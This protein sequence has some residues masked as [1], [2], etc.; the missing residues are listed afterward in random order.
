MTPVNAAGAPVSGLFVGELPRALL[1]QLQ[2]LRVIMEQELEAIDSLLRRNDFNLQLMATV[3]ALMLGF[4]L[5]F[6]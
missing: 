1:L 3:P 4:T 6:I 5:V 2:Y